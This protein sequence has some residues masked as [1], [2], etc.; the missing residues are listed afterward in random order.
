MNI[1]LLKTGMVALLVSSSPLHAAFLPDN[2]L[3]KE[4]AEI[5]LLNSSNITQVEFSQVVD[6]VINHYRPLAKKYGGTLR[7]WKSWKSSTV[8]A[9]ATELL[10][11]WLVRVNGGL[12]RRPE[13]SADGLALVVCHELGHHIAGFPMGNRW[14]AIE[15][16][17]DYFATQACAKK[18][19]KDETEKNKLAALTVD[20]TAQA[21]CDQV[22]FTAAQRNICYRTANASLGL[23]R[24]LSKL[25]SGSAEPK[26]DTP[27]TTVVTETFKMHPAAQCRLDTLMQG[28]VCDRLPQEGLIPGR[29]HR[30]RKTAVDPEREAAENS[31]TAL[32]GHRVG[33][34]PTC[35]FKPTI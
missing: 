23:A 12:A 24:L 11:Q 9:F 20:P 17:S 22:Y 2:D 18:I 4:D 1:T 19:W 10:G 15:G 31:C 13:I 25:R 35:W 8:N 5:Q 3:D 32:T 30:S 29:K 33:L 16:Q 7:S 26:F 14:A 21:Q 34:R 6:S 28:A 27:D